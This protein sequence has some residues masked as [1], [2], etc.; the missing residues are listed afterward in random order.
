MKY[1]Q[2]IEDS[3]LWKHQFEDSAKGKGNMAGS[4]YYVVNQSGKGGDNIKYIP[5]VAQDIV[6]AKARIRK[7]KKK[8]RKVK[9]QSTTKRRGG[10]KVRK[11]VVVKRKKRTPK[12]KKATRKKA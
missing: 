2:R 9:K 1:I 5:P 7:Y 12:K 10:K 6:M 11:R 3:A 8:T 4:S